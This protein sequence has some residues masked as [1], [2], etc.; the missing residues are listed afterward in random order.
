MTYRRT[1]RAAIAG[2]AL[3]SCAVLAAAG[4]VT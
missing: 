2:A 3:V 4:P 1:L